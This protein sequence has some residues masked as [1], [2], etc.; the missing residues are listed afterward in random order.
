MDIFKLETKMPRRLIE[1]KK[2]ELK[3]EEDVY[4]LFI[5]L[6]SDETICFKLRKENSLA[7]NQ[8]GNIFNYDKMT[9]LFLLQKEFYDN[10]DKIFNFIDIALNEKKINL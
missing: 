10:M 8:Y 3:Y 7:L 4:S 5:K 2:Y 6:Y 1:S 9:T